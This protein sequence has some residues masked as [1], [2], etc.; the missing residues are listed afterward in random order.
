VSAVEGAIEAAGSVGANT[1]D[2]AKR[3]VVGALKAADEAGGQ[4]GKTVRDALLSAASLPRDVI[5]KVVK[6]SEA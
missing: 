3:A 5:E 4:A 2:A 1:S 6:G